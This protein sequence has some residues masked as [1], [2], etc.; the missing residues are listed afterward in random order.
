M[1]QC[2]PQMIFRAAQS[3]MGG[4]LGRASG[5]AQWPGIAGLFLWVV[6]ERVVG[7]PPRA[8]PAQMPAA[9]CLHP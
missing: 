6:Q 3:H 8:G 2:A 7:S 4:L 1:T 9:E 5:G